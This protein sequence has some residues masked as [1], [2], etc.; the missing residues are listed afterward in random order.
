MKKILV[1]DDEVQ[2]LKALSRMFLETEYEIFTAENGMEALQLMETS[3]IDM[4]ISDMRMPIMDGYKLLSL[5]KEK[6]PKI[7][8]IILS[9]YADEKLMFRALLHNLAKLY[10]FKPW[11]N[12]D[13]LKNIDRLFTDDIVLNSADLV[14]IVSDLEC[15][16]CMPV[17][18]EKMISLIENEDIDSLITE[19]ENDPDISALLMQV[20]KSAVY[21]AMPGTVKQ[22]AIYIGLHNLKSFMNWACAVSEIKQTDDINSEPELLWKHAYLTNRIFLFLYETFFHKQP[23]EAAMFA[24]LMHNLGLIILTKSLRK[25]GLLSKAEL[26]ADDYIK[27]ELG[28]QEIN[29]QEIGAHFLDL[30][31]LAFPIYEVSLYHHRPFDP[32]IVNHEL[33]SCVHIAQN[34]AWKYLNASALEPI[35]P[36]VFAGIGISADDFE[37]RLARYLK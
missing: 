10:I 34:Y 11:N 32:C 16:S 22:A 3:D 33:V 36:D 30:W 20:C 4:V 27:L 28:E 23:P 19:M 17:N 37:K 5:V 14:K 9:G 15:S 24:G 31:D 7:I 25:K 21:G 13:F 26:T 1:V 12:N 18:C 35:S 2:I 8:R 6:Y 29:H